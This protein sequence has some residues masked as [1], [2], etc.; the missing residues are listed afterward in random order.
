MKKVLFLVLLIIVSCETPNDDFIVQRLVDGDLIGYDSISSTNAE[1]LYR[2]GDNV[3]VYSAVENNGHF[4]S[5]LKLIKHDT[6]EK[7]FSNNLKISTTEANY[8]LGVFNSV[9]ENAQLVK[10]NFT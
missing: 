1:I 4:D 2:S 7:H 10:G 8:K 3:V 5:G 9:E 6:Q